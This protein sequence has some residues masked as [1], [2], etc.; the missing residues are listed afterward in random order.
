MNG[1]VMKI[2]KSLIASIAAMS[3]ML[4]VFMFKHPVLADDTY[5]LW[6]GETQVTSSNCSDILGDATASFDPS[7]NTLTLNNPTA[8]T[9]HH[10]NALIYAQNMDLT[11]KGALRAVYQVQSGVY[12]GIYIDGGSLT[13]SEGSGITTS[14]VISVQSNGIYATD[15]VTIN[16]GTVWTYGAAG[17][18]T[19]PAGLT[20]NDG[21]VTVTGYYKGL[22]LN[23]GT[24]TVNGGKISTTVTTSTTQPF[25]LYCASAPVI[26][27][28]LQM[29]PED[30]SFNETRKTMIGSD[31]RPVRTLTIEAPLTV[32]VLPSA[33][34]ITYG[35]TLN[36]STLSGGEVQFEGTVLTG[37]F[38]WSSPE[39]APSVSDSDTTLYEVTFTPTDT[40]YGIAKCK[41]TL[42]VNKPADV[43]DVIAMIEAL[44]E[45]DDVTTSDESAITAVEQAFMALPEDQRVLIPEELINKLNGCDHALQVALIEELKDVLYDL[46][47]EVNGFGDEYYDLLP[48]DLGDALVEAFDNAT[49]IL[50]DDDCTLQ[51]VE[52]ALNE[53]YDAYEASVEYIEGL[54]PDEPDDPDEGEVT[55]PVLTPEQILEMGVRNLVERL[56]ENALGRRYDVAGRDAW[57]NLIMH[58]NGTGSQVIRGIIG[59]EE[60]AGRQLSDEEFVI[61]L[62]SAFFNR[63]PTASEVANWTAALAAGS[64]RAD[65]VEAFIASPEW[66]STCAYY[67]VNV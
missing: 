49:D 25:G 62:Y 66:A 9:G 56:Y 24:L 54:D 60:F 40:S 18:I 22:F 43:N 15:G 11:I 48:E 61:T 45:P 16:G 30:A 36:D 38:A 7:T 58:Q 53:L 46:I 28:F 67:R 33:S 13:I 51:E 41:I 55:E 23:N 35:Q 21:D 44:P 6:L 26:A 4:S 39:T 59:S 29:T 19:C 20:V 34:A 42:T 8:F 27:G 57:V 37:T 14:I 10:S 2:G 64:T 65:I 52:A 1:R 32:T 50:L 17:G 3:L 63:V 47:T 5:S 12:N 31:G